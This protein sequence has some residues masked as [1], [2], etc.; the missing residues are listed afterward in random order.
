MSRLPLHARTDAILRRLVRREANQQ[1]Q[2]VL[3]T[4]RSY[5]IFLKSQPAVLQKIMSR[6]NILHKSLFDFSCQK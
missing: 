1:I 2:K 5:V 6:F 3:A 4:N